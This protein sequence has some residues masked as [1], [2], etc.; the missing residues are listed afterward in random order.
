MTTSDRRHVR[1]GDRRR[2]PRGG[3]RTSD[4][5]GRYP[6][7]LVADSYENARTPCARYLDRFGFH[8]EEASDGAQAL[9]RIEARQPH[10]ILIEAGLPNLS[11]ARMVRHL[12]E[13]QKAIP[14]IVMVSDFEQADAQRVPGSATGVLVKPFALSTMLQEVRRVL[15]EHPP[16]SVESRA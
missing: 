9:L 10:A 14:V 8:V 2:V 15:R 1:A 6:N 16:D 7:L 4:Q 13:Q 11:A 5:P 12:K 3:R